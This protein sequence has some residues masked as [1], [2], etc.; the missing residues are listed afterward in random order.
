MKFMINSVVR[1]AVVSIVLGQYAEPTSKGLSVWSLHV[2]HVNC[3]SVETFRVGQSVTLTCPY[4]NNGLGL[5]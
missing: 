2:F 3:S 4:V 5:G 1:G